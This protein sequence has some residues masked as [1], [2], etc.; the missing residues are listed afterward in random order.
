MSGHHLREDSRWWERAKGPIMQISEY[1]FTWLNRDREKRLTQE[2]EWRRRALERAPE[3]EPR[4][5]AK[6]FRGRRAPAASPAARN[7]AQPRQPALRQA[8]PAG[9]GGHVAR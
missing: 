5:R 1:S 6:W 3:A 2:L 4:R 9:C 8:E 7:V